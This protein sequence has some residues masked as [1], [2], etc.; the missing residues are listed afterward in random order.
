MKKRASRDK[1]VFGS[2]VAIDFK[3]YQ[4]SIKELHTATD[5]VKDS[6]KA[7]ISFLQ[8]AN[9]RALI[10]RDFTITSKPK[11][12]KA[13]K[14]VKVKYATMADLMNAPTDN[15]IK[16]RERSVQK[17]IKINEAANKKL[18]DIEF[19]VKSDII[20]AN[21]I[22]AAKE[23]KNERNNKKLVG[24][25]TSKPKTKQERSTNKA[26]DFKREAEPK[27]LNSTRKPKTL[28]S[29]KLTQSVRDE[30][31]EEIVAKKYERA[32]NHKKKNVDGHLRGTSS[33]VAIGLKR[34]PVVQILASDN[35][36]KPGILDAILD[37]YNNKTDT[38]LRRRIPARS[39][40]E[41]APTYTSG[42]SNRVT[43]AQRRA[44]AAS[45]IVEDVPVPRPSILGRLGGATSAIG[46]A[47][48][49]ARGAESLEELGTSVLGNL[50]SSGVAHVVEHGAVKGAGRLAAMAA[51][52]WAGGALGSIGGT[53][54]MPGVGTVAGE[55]AGAALGPILVE[56]LI[57]AISGSGDEQ[58]EATE[59]QTK[60]LDAQTK[61]LQ[62][63][64]KESKK[65][66]DD[67]EDQT[68]IL[69]DVGSSIVG[70]VSDVVHKAG[71]Y[72]SDAGSAIGS[73]AFA[74]EEAVGNS[75]DY[76][77]KK[78]EEA[79][80]WVGSKVHDAKEY[81]K[82]KVKNFKFDPHI[83]NVISEASADEHVDPRFLRSLAYIESKGDPNAVS[84]T[85]AKGLGQFTKGTGRMYGLYGNGVDNRFDPSANAHATARLATDNAK[86]LRRMDIE[87]TP[88]LLYMAHQQ[89]AGAKSGRRGGV[90]EIV[91]AAREGKGW[92]QLSP[93]L[94]S[95]MSVNSSRG[96]SA[97]EY[98][99]FWEKKYRVA[100]AIANK[101]FQTD[102]KEA[103]DSKSSIAI[104]D[105][106]NTIPG[107][108]L[109]GD[110][111][112]PVEESMLVNQIAFAKAPGQLEPTAGKTIADATL[113]LQQKAKHGSKSAKAKSPIVQQSEYSKVLNA[114]ANALT[115]LNTP[116]VNVD[117]PGVVGSTDYIKASMV[118]PRSVEQSPTIDNAK[119]GELYPTSNVNN[120][121]SLVNNTF[122][123]N[124]SVAQS[125][126][127]TSVGSLNVTAQSV[128]V[129]G[130]SNQQQEP[131][132]TETIKN[133]YQQQPANSGGFVNS[134]KP[135]YSVLGNNPIMQ[136]PASMFSA[137]PNPFSSL[138]IPSF[139]PSIGMP[140]PMSGVQGVIGGFNNIISAPMA[141]INTAQS[142]LRN[143]A[144]L[145]QGVENIPGA[146]QRSESNF[147]NAPRNFENSM[148]SITSMP[149][150]FKSITRGEHRGLMGG[151]NEAQNALGFIGSAPSRV[152]GTIS[153]AMNAPANI[154][155]PIMGAVNNITNNPIVGGLMGG[156][157]SMFGM[158]QHP[159]QPQQPTQYIQ[160]NMSGITPVD[161]SRHMDAAITNPEQA[162]TVKQAQGNTFL[163]SAGNFFQKQSGEEYRPES[164]GN[165]NPVTHTDTDIVQPQASAVG[166]SIVSSTRIPTQDK[167]QQSA[168]TPDFHS[169]VSGGNE[170]A[171]N[172]T[173]NSITSS[174]ATITS[175]ANVPMVAERSQYQPMSLQMPE[176][177]DFPQPQEKNSQGSI[178]QKGK[179]SNTIIHSS[180][181]GGSSKPSIDD[182]PINISDSGLLL[183]NVG[184]I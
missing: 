83:A 117:K 174:P 90:S 16:L 153:G 5:S 169:L 72:A 35:D 105:S 107:S 128:N 100:D 147:E 54:A 74:A 53:L 24:T 9:G 95:N 50:A 58:L 86:S 110:Y 21:A 151:L 164:I 14:A 96:K 31:L 55:V 12:V 168:I 176:Y 84:P 152:L 145:T 119:V 165:S 101:D 80:S 140:N 71:E 149:E 36:E 27:A 51:G 70:F 144:N 178:S 141:A 113:V 125:P 166:S 15:E 136:Q 183:L 26:L 161:T 184:Y 46:G 123:T 134:S 76:I 7:I 133:L 122:A 111:G 64:K 23:L 159:N 92:E 93:E 10:E 160:R 129:S 38:T 139:N 146:M 115:A 13:P 42:R 118:I 103:L 104:K 52:R 130:P 150:Q 68:S 158:G 48:S 175:A 85:G 3:E 179:D 47:A 156:I 40:R 120:Q 29:A 22:S 11:I 18:S 60:V 59:S 170:Y 63:N 8:S 142:T 67:L 61:L 148:R 124:S 62:D 49:A 2:N 182:I 77:N 6:A 32:T 20:K 126:L 65:Q 56:K 106:G 57:D 66:T 78:R 39:N 41:R 94:Q 102:K 17:Q 171:S 88:E 73:G 98:L 121:S 28:Q 143:T 79:G 132:T 4:K 89:G 167:L 45:N 1:K 87:A 127:A 137:M 109:S 112:K 19:K 37:H 81:V 30:E 131:N 155:S 34:K 91:K 138:S 82:G 135:S 75:F 69:E 157:S 162:A 33:S 180:S 177:P 43:R 172:Y 163:G 114:Q 25:S 181:G 44:R 97:Q 173:N 108:V 154:L 99:D 116:V